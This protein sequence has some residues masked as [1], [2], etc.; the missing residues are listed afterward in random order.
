MEITGRPAIE[1]NEALGISEMKGIKLVATADTIRS[2]RPDVVLVKGTTN[3]TG[4]ELPPEGGKAHWLCVLAKQGGSWK[5]QA[6]HVGV[7]PPPPQK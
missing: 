1:K 2:I 6:L 3:I 5:I 7:P 4:G